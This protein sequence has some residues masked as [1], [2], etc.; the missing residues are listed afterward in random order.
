MP[1]NSVGE[2][3]REHRLRAGLTQREL[4]A[5]AGVGLRSLRDIEQ[6]RA[7]PRARSVQRLAD[8][9]GMSAAERDAL[10]AA[11]RPARSGFW[12]GV[13]GPLVVRRDD[14]P[15]PVTSARQR[16][17][18]GL[19]A[20]HNGQTVGVHDIVDAL[21]GEDPPRTGRHQV[22]VLIGR[23]RAL[24]EPERPAG[25]PGHALVAEDSGYRLRLDE[26]R[27][28]LAA[29]D[30][31]LEQARYEEA[32]DL[33]RGPALADLRDRLGHHPTLVA[34]DRRRVA[35]T[36]ALADGADG[37]GQPERA[38]P[39]LQRAAHDE[40][41]HEGLHERLVRALLGQGEQ[42]AAREAYE[43]IRAR[44]AEELG[45]APGPEL[46]AA[47]PEAPPLVPAQLPAG[48]AAF[49]GRRPELERL[50]ALLAE[51]GRHPGAVVIATIG[52]T[53]G[54]GKTALALHWAHRVAARFPDGQL[55]V[56]LQG[57]DDAGPMATAEAVRGFLDSLGVPPGRIP[58]TLQAQ[59]GL[60]RSLV[61][62][63]RVLVVLDNAR[64]A[65]QVRP[66]LPGTPTA[67]AVVTSRNLL[68]AL[69]A[70]DGAHPV[71]L[72]AMPTGDARELLAGRIGRRRLAAE[73]DAAERIVGACAGLPLALGITAARA[74]QT[75]F[76]LS[77][78]ADELTDSRER[79]DALDTW[80]AGASVR[81][82]FS[83]SYAALGTPAA[84]LFRLLG[85]HPGPEVTASAAA[86]LAGLSLTT[87]RR[88]L[89][90]LAHANLLTELR[91]GRFG[92]HDLLRAH[93]AELVDAHEPEPER[94]AAV[95]RLL[96]HY[97]HTAHAAERHLH[98]A[99]DPMPI[100]LRPAVTG[101]TVDPLADARQSMAWLEVNLRPLLAAMR[102]FP[103]AASDERLWQLAWVL[104][105]FLNR[106]GRW[107]DRLVVWQAGLDAARRLENGL[108][109]AHAQRNIA[110]GHA[111]LGEFDAARKHFKLA[112]ER[113]THAGDLAGQAQTHHN[114]GFV[115]QR[116]GQF[117]RALEHV[118]ESLRLFRAAGNRWGEAEALNA[119]A[120]CHIHLGRPE[121]ALAWCAES[122]E[123]NRAIA[124]PEGEAHAWDTLG[125]AQHHLGR[126][127]EAAR[128]YQRGLTL[129]REI[130]DRYHEA[131]TLV[132]L[133]DNA[134]AAGASGAADWREAL[135]ILTDLDNPVA[136]AVRSRLASN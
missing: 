102:Q 87:T 49:A 26:H 113:F 116:S 22:H 9:V 41:L 125:L 110:G 108:A 21:W 131:E 44:L 13:L 23:L 27:L 8:A 51:S 1:G 59:L 126:Y 92:T 136:D 65:E 124:N 24:I 12:L 3:L 54:V 90:E 114:L 43:R 50:D 82:V 135:R 100:P 121:E 78:L 10:L 104:D 97:V 72:Q 32:L 7:R 37:A 67:F 35:A 39:L 38:V 89:A 17:L 103:R 115:S 11:V 70:L 132:R 33:W 69:V 94:R 74:R 31:M 46:R 18:L 123:S 120:W 86:S 58:A 28:D 88:L 117:D 133:G 101:T 52:G 15:V 57:F 53:A 55:Y 30:R 56:N 105:T 62:G 107:T 47:L 106:G 45:I 79:L 34:L 83:W 96:D 5:R 68:S 2:A 36:L 111:R 129:L 29:F 6:G 48:I 128:S 85:L 112:L 61:A 80:N 99:R 91:P 25:A 75:G 76:D 20:V 134:Q 98:P 63:K 66:L 127:A 73:P 71:A 64:D 77:T 42:A 16:Q 118:R 95:A 81:A 14:E 93:A 119:V 4:A 40:P 130:G 84:R 109:E 122:L 60:Y 19:L